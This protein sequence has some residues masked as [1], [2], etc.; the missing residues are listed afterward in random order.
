MVQDSL[1]DGGLGDE[2]EDLHRRAA[3]GTG[4]RVDLVDAKD[5]LGPPLTQSAPGKHGARCWTGCSRTLGLVGGACAVGVGTV[6]M[7]P[8]LVGLRDVNEH[9]GQ[10]LEGVDDTIVVEVMSGLGLVEDE[11]GVWMIASRE[12]FTGERIK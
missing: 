9:A 7:D 4:Q 8:V 5:Q 12:R 10:K 2:G 6:E 11:L 1:D 3:P